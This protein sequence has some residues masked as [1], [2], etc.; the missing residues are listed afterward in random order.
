MEVIIFETKQRLFI[1]TVIEY[2]NQSIQIFIEEVKAG[3]VEKDE[4]E[5]QTMSSLTALMTL[6]VDQENNFNAGIIF[7]EI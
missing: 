6:L 3:F 5:Y 4:L 2:Y 1:F 7:L